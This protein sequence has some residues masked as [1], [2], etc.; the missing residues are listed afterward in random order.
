MLHRLFETLQTQKQPDFQRYLCLMSHL[1]HL[2][3]SVLNSGLKKNI[4]TQ[5]S[6]LLLDWWKQTLNGTTKARTK[7][8]LNFL[9]DH[10]G[11]KRR[12]QKDRTL[13]QLPPHSEDNHHSDQGITASFPPAESTPGHN[14]AAVPCPETLK[15]PNSSLQLCSPDTGY[16][17]SGAEG[18]KAWV[19]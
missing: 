18:Q 6:K 19:P 17:T 5:T 10:G 13:L 8:K 2:G 14:I 15:E 9:P 7:H 12:W 16:Q 11:G 3:T 1:T 4:Q